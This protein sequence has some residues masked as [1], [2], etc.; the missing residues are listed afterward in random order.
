MRGQHLYKNPAIEVCGHCR[1]LL[2]WLGVLSWLF[3][4][5]GLKNCWHGSGYW[6]C[7]LRSSFWVRCPWPHSYGN[8]YCI[9]CG[10]IMNPLRYKF[11][12]PWLFPT[13]YYPGF[14]LGWWCLSRG[15]WMRVDHNCELICQPN[16]G[17]SQ[18]NWKFLVPQIQGRLIKFI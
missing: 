13:R 7:N 2:P 18:S 6:T 5:P 11:V 12:F 4:N 10:T 17:I 1:L 14:S 16:P 9:S 15:S 8:P 3:S